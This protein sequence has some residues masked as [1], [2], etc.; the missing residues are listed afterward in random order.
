M[1]VVSDIMMTTDHLKMACLSVRTTADGA[2]SQDLRVFLF[3]FLF[4]IE[5]NCGQGLAVFDR[6]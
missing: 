6:K 1:D 2:I 3:R 4:A 5:F